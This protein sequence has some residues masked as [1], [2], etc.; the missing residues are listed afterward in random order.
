MRGGSSLSLMIA[1]A[2]VLSIAG[3]VGGGKSIYSMNDGAVIKDFS[4]DTNKI[5]DDEYATLTLTIEN[6]GA[7]KIPGNTEVYIYG[8]PITEDDSKKGKEWYVSN[9]GGFDVNDNGEYM[10]LSL[11]SDEFLPPDPEMNIPGTSKMFYVE[12]EAPNVPDGMSNNYNFYTRL[13]FPYNTT[14]ITKIVVTSSNELR[15][16]GP[17]KSKAATINS[18]GP[19]HISIEGT[20]NVRPSRNSIPLVFKITNVGGGFATTQDYSCRVDPEVK[21]RDKV[22]VVVTVDGD[23]VEDCDNVEVRLRNGEGTLYCTYT[24]EEGAPRTEYNVVAT[25]IYN[26]Y[27]T[28]STSIE[29][30]DSMTDSD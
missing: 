26:Y 11:S 21:E 10:N 17:K 24:F 2:I 14:S 8:T 5:Y 29:V 25:A 30:M 13:C 18:A 1:L 28:S 16:E 22:K 9:N 3:C 6:V 23:V 12:L 7:K 15:Y 19:I 27:V 20:P 4:F